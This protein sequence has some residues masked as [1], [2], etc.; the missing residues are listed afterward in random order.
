M[1]FSAVYVWR[2]PMPKMARVLHVSMKIG[3][4]HYLFPSG[5]RYCDEGLS[6]SRKVSGDFLT[7]FILSAAGAAV[8][9]AVAKLN[10]APKS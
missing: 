10:N 8:V 4:Y 5:D 1:L 6:I 3:L 2:I 9:H 7:N